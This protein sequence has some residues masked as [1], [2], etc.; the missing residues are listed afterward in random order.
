MPPVDLTHAE[1]CSRQLLM[2]IAHYNVLTTMCFYC[3]TCDYTFTYCS[4]NNLE[5]CTDVFASG[6]LDINAQNQLEGEIAI[7]RGSMHQIRKYFSVH[8]NVSI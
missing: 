7:K 6:T 5:V 3:L 2:H 4:P 8:H 1:Q